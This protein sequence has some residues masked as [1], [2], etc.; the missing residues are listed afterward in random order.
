MNLNEKDTLIL[1]LI[2]QGFETMAELIDVSDFGGSVVNASIELLDQ[3]RYIERYGLIG[4][5]FW[6]FKLTDKG[7]QVLPPLSAKERELQKKGLSS[8]DIETLK[9]FSRIG[10]VIA[11]QYIHEN[12]PDADEQRQI[13]AS[14]VKLLRKGYLG[15]F[16]FTRRRVKI[17]NKGLELIK[18]YA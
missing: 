12:T 18:A 7:E 3:N 15:E 6:S 1:S 5:N 13:A 16:G 14:I 8:I 17:N 11:S 10:A 2:Q 4:A 9:L